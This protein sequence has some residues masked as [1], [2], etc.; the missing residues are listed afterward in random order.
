[1]ILGTKP[2]KQ[3]DTQHSVN[4]IELQAVA[5]SIINEIDTQQ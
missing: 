5:L 4:P 3:Q 1:M 2:V